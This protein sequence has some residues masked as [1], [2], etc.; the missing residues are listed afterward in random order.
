MW[1]DTMFNSVNINSEIKI[2]RMGGGE[3]L[4]N[5]KYKDDL[6]HLIEIIDDKYPG[7]DSWFKKKV[8]PGLKEKERFAFLV[9]AKDKPVGSAIIKKSGSAKLC[10]LRILPEYRERGIG[11]LLFSLLARETRAYAGSVHFTAP[12]TTYQESIPFFDKLGFE[13]LGEA[14]RQ[15]RLFDKEVFCTVNAKDLWMNVLKHLD[16]MIEQFT[17]LGNPIHPDLV[18]SLKPEY[19]KK[20]KEKKKSVEIRRKFSEKWRGA[21]ALLYASAP[22]QEFFGEARID[23][24]VEDEPNEIWKLFGSDIGVEKNKFDEYCEGKE[25]VSALVLSEIDIYKQSI[26]KVQLDF[27][28]GKELKAPQNYCAIKEGT[29]WPTAVSLNYLLLA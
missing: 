3:R 1:R 27:L 28:L 18:M 17:L 8:M 13:C 15:Y 6:K 20:M 9:F 11:N 19:A 25:K 10:S 26:L 22:L 4:I 21:Y 23:D 12:L 24:I 7:I 2:V 29:A 16:D 14:N 5:E